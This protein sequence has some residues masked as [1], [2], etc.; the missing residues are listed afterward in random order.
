MDRLGTNIINSHKKIY[1]ENF[2]V[3]FLFWILFNKKGVSQILVLDSLDF[4]EHNPANQNIY[5]KAFRKIFHQIE[6]IRLPEYIKLPDKKDKKNLCWQA[7]IKTLEFLDSDHFENLSSDCIKPFLF[8][9]QDKNIELAAK[10]YFA[11][12]IFQKILF[13]LQWEDIA[14]NHERLIVFESNQDIFLIRDFLFDKKIITPFNRPG[15]FKRLAYNIS[16]A[17]LVILSPFIIR[18]IFRRGLNLKKIIQKSY[19]TAIHLVIGFP[20]LKYENSLKMRKT[21]Y[22]DD[23]YFKYNNLDPSKNIFVQGRWDYPRDVQD[24]NEIHAKQMGSEYVDDKKLRIPLNIFLYD[25]IFLGI[26]RNIFVFFTIIFRGKPLSFSLIFSLQKIYQSYL[27][28]LV[29]CQYIRVKIFISRDDY[30]IDHITR[31]IIQDSYGLKNFGIAHSTFIEPLSIPF[32]A[33]LYFHKY[34]TAGEGYRSLWHPYWENNH[35]IY[36]VGPHRDH[37]IVKASE[38]SK[39][40]GVPPP[41]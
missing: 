12:Q 24:D 25:Y 3:Q 4:Y 10:K 18:D 11:A 7:N 16:A 23:I 30:D 13:Y 38:D 15:W 28:H 33:H 40:E 39:I 26:F 8:Y 2:S 20:S 21:N 34:Y 37:A 35:S 31:T 27:Y 1:L 32:S 41:K 36:P 9:T 19:D 22:G 14:E 6:I 17:F 5:E 29:F